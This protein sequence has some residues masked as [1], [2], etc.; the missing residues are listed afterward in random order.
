MDEL[1]HVTYIKKTV[2]NK[3][4]VYTVYINKYKSPQQG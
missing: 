3:V 4:S 2:T 1:R